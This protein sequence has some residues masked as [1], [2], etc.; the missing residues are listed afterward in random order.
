MKDP[1]PHK[2]LNAWKY[3]ME[4]VTNVYRITADLP[5]SEKYGLRSQMRR[6]AV[7]VPSNIAEGA[8][9]R[10]K[11][12]FANYL[13][14]AIGSLSELDTQVELSFRLNFLTEKTKNGLT[15]EINKVKAVI[16]GLKKSLKN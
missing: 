2:N 4:L 5:E 11:S 10:T 1:T 9:G 8:T 3:A 14:I 6:A 12:H 13:G 7:S 15:D 16:Y